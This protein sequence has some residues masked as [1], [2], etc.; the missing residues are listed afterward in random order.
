MTRIGAWWQS[1]RA[2]LAEAQEVTPEPTDNDR[3][4]YWFDVHWND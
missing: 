3:Q 4:D 2:N 1:Y